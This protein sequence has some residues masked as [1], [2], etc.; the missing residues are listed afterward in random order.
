MLL[1]EDDRP[2]PRRDRHRGKGM[3]VTIG[4]VRPDIVLGVR[5]LLLVHNTIRGAAGASIINAELM[6]RRGIVPG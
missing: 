2:Q 4:R 3:T 1:D 6:V 5:F